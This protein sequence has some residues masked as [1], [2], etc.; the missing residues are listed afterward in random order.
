MSPAMF[1]TGLWLYSQMVPWAVIPPETW[2]WDSMK[3]DLVYVQDFYPFLL[4]KLYIFR[5]FS[6]SR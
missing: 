4:S 3:Y 6:L 5:T 2:V 1:V